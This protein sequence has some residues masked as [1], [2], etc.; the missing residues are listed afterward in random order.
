MKK[1]LLFLIYCWISLSSVLA[2]EG[3]WMPLFIDQMNY[4]DMQ[5][6][7][8]KLTAEDIYSYN[9]SSIKDAIVQFGGGCTASVISD[10][11]LLLTNHHCGYGAL[12]AKSSVMHDYLTDGFWANS[13]KEELPIEG[14]TVKFLISIENVTTD[15]LSK[16]SGAANED[17]RN[18]K[19]KE[20]AAK[21]EKDAVEGT[22]YVANLKSFYE[23]NE[24]YLFV[25]AIYKDVRLVGAPPTSIGKFGGE[26]DNWMWPRHT[27]DFALFRIYTSPD[28]KPAEYSDK[29]VP[30]KSKYSLPINIGGYK[31]D[32]FT[33][34][35]GYPGATERYLTSNGIDSYINQTYP[36]KIAIRGMKL[37]IMLKDM[38]TFPI[39]RMKYASKYASI[40][41]YWKNYIGVVKAVKRLKIEDKKRILENLFMDWCQKDP[42]AMEKYGQLFSTMEEAYKEIAKYNVARI[43]YQEA[44][45]GCEAMAAARH[46]KVLEDLLSAQPLD[47][48]ALNNKV[49]ELKGIMTQIYKNFSVNTDTKMMKAMLAM[50]Y[51]SVPREQQPHFM[52]STGDKTKGDFSVFVDN[53]YKE[54]IFSDLTL[55]E[56]FL[57]APSLKTLEKDQMYI[58]IM[59]FTEANNALSKN[60]DAANN[61]LAVQKR[62]FIAGL[63]EM[64]PD[65]K[66]YPD[67]NSTMRLSYGRV[68]DYRPADAVR[69]D[70]Y[71]TLDGL[72]AKEDS[73]NWEF[74]VP[75]YLKELWKKKDYGQY[76]DNGE[77]RVCFL[78]DNDITGGSSGSP[79]INAKGEII[80]ITFD[81]NWEAMSN[82]FL[83]EPEMQR[84]INVDIRY[85]LFVIDKYANAQNLIKE[86]KIVN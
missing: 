4:S 31:K 50:Y 23:G 52:L 76:A 63:H 60:L 15:V 54:S 38:K 26:A 14:L 11:G 8:L 16:I 39:V 36:T 74:V 6:Y 49:D 3:F 7:G 82:N 46:F 80:G 30:L 70:Y 25:Y 37:D 42:K 17:E 67:A 48:D 47:K 12:Q 13:R 77:L 21:I 58:A 68:L 51:T 81:G 83:F 1:F 56:E 53:A 20:I 86:M 73:S 35:I 5:K 85:V 66:F 69:Y 62:L 2:D 40:S 75:A 78:T 84:T 45:L 64:F 19:I 43:Y 41:N 44:V 55:I 65:K 9:H 72:M 18:A 24:F 32:D 59:N 27:G 22:Q 10:Q 57:K 61:K 79:V 34:L 33:M 71:T 28:G 29:N